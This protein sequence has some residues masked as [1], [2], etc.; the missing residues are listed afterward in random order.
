MRK[1]SSVCFYLRGLK[2]WAAAYLSLVVL[3]VEEGVTA[4]NVDHVEGM[5]SGFMNDGQVQK[6]VV[7]KGKHKS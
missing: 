6:P 2:G 4:R 1:R 7:E 5:F 3:H